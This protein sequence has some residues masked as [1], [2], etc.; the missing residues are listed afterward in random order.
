MHMS[1]N[2]FKI[3]GIILSVFINLL[4]ILN[5]YLFFKKTTNGQQHVIYSI[6]SKVP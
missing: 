1:I 4:K 3:I 5:Q 6:T 2:L